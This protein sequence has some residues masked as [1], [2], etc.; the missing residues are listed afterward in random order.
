ME[1]ESGNLP[2]PWQGSQRENKRS[3]WEKQ[4]GKRVRVCKREL[5][6]LG[7]EEREEKE[8]G[9]LGEKRMVGLEDMR[10]TE[11]VEQILTLSECEHNG[12]GEGEN[13]SGSG[14]GASWLRRARVGFFLFGENLIFQ[15]TRKNLW[16][17]Y[18]FRW[19]NSP[20][21]INLNIFDKLFFV[22]NIASEI[23]FFL[24]VFPWQK[25]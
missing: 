24:V 3:N 19:K 20:S 5:E 9:N 21:V 4:R 1:K 12:Q 13:G 18:N 6:E 16:E 11:G 14:S 23:I 2:K 8:D 10:E 25:D 22:K 15:R 17:Y 7:K